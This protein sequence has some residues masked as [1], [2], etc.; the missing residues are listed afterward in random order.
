MFYV[1]RG[2]A[3]ALLAIGLVGCGA[4]SDSGLADRG[5][6]RQV[7]GSV[8]VAATPTVL[9]GS[10]VDY[11]F[12][13]MGSYVDITHIATARITRVAADARIR[14]AD[15]TLA[16]D[17][18]GN[19]GK[20]YRLYAAAFNRVPDVRGLSYWIDV[21][22]RGA[23]L[24]EIAKGFAASAEFKQLYGIN[25]TN[26]SI[27]ESL[28]RNIL[29]RD[30][31]YAGINY[32]V[33]ILQ[34][35]SVADALMGFSESPENQQGVYSA[36]V[37]GIA[38]REPGAVYSAVANAGVNRTGTMGTA[39]V[40]DGTGSL[41]GSGAQTS[42]AWAFTERPALSNAVLRNADTSLPSFIPDKPG[43]YSIA[44]TF[45]DG[46]T[47]VSSS[48]KVVVFQ[49]MLN[50]APL[51]V[52]YS[53]GLDKMIVSSSNPN[54]LK[55]VDPFS[56]D[57][58]TVSLPAAVKNFS[59]SPDGRR[60]IVLHESVA[61]LVNL[62]SAVVVKSFA[63]GGSHTDAFLTANGVAYFI[64]QSGGQWVRPSVVYFDAATGQAL[65]PPEGNY[66]GSFYG[67]QTGIYAPTKNK[68]YLMS[69]GLSPADINYFTI[70]PTNS[71]VTA[72][73]DS[74]YHGDYSMSAPLYLSE[75]EDILFTS[76]GNYF[77][78]STLRYAGTFSQ[79]VRS[80]SNSAA[81]D[82]TL[83]FA[84]SGPNYPANYRRYTGSLFFSD[85]TI[86]LPVID[87]KQSYGI[88]IFHSVNGSRV[89]LVQTGSAAADG[90]GLKY[91]AIPL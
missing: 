82:E 29:K 65:T 86:A 35:A 13:R 77:Y 46:K 4:G 34:R 91:Y 19:A 8:Q 37:N 67:T 41:E 12:D 85:T 73:G 64:G 11:K 25:P 39:V 50:F 22:D 24:W 79:S 2:V 66:M 17:I 62:D 75:N 42:Y 53:K 78:T 20:V 68:V 84:G 43:T 3:L 7:Q 10:Y 52:H 44:L 80:L 69:Q 26:Q 51:D 15:Y 28:Y 23:S 18:D 81:K 32:W 89:A 61:S 72:M 57:V 27:V 70:N 31:E 55:I 33:G 76:S 47:S 30:G 90:A 36:I 14:F 71:E 88:K 60:A 54:A 5:A 6:A 40:L 56:G 1:Q 16:M 59:L 48:V 45:S 63:T 49:S 74:P 87:G 9:A 21:M 58:A 38:Y 83:I